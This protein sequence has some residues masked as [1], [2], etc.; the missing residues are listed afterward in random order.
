[1]RN[2]GYMIFM[3]ICKVKKSNANSFLQSLLES[4]SSTGYSFKFLRDDRMSNQQAMKNSS[5]WLEKSPNS[6]QTAWTTVCTVL[7]LLLRKC[8]KTSRMLQSIFSKQTKKPLSCHL[9]QWPLLTPGLKHCS[10]SDLE[11]RVFLEYKQHLLSRRL[12]EGWE[13]ETTSW[14]SFIS[15]VKASW[16]RGHSRP[17]SIWE[18]SFRTLAV[19]ISK[20][21]KVLLDLQWRQI[22]ENNDPQGC[23]L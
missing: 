8:I 15:M 20:Q 4:A 1:M 18:C 2:F 21:M 19:L 13:L 7:L 9:W 5:P 11:C 12:S 22:H 23:P 14:T 16:T 3:N 10:S 6:L 17:N